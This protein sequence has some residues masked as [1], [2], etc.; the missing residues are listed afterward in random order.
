[1][2]ID[3]EKV[4]LEPWKIITHHEKVTNKCHTCICTIDFPEPHEQSH[5]QMSYMYH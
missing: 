2:K 3:H 4:K 1:M 5:E